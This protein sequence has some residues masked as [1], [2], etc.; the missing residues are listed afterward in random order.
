M[1]NPKK[2][3]KYVSALIGPTEIECRGLVVRLPHCRDDGDYLSR[4]GARFRRLEVM[5]TRTAVVVRR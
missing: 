3:V 5:R 2:D 4:R 1:Q